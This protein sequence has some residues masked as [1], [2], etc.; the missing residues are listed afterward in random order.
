MQEDHGGGDDDDDDPSSSGGSGGGGSV[1]ASLPECAWVLSVERE[2]LLRDF[3]LNDDQLSVV[4][5][6]AAWL[7][8]GGG[9]SGGKGGRAP[10]AGAAAA[11]VE[12]KTTSAAGVAS[13]IV[14]VHGIF[15]RC[16]CGTARPHVCQ[17][18]IALHLGRT[19]AR[20]TCWWR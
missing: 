16:V 14:L 1:F 20:A 7:A 4:D 19:A 5:A 11:E 18:T 17:S 9:G 8:S 12:F 13:P 6:C 3:A 10:P 15:G 2:A